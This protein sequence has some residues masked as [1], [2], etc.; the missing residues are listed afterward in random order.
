ME[1]ESKLLA[2]ESEYKARIVSLQEQL[3]EVQAL[4]DDYEVRFSM[5]DGDHDFLFQELND[6]LRDSLTAGDSSSPS[7][8]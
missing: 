2:M 7:K 5:M 6:A 4:A 3:R 8:K 1:Y